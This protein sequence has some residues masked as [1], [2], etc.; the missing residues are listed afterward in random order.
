MSGLIYYFKKKMLIDYAEIYQNEQQS[1]MV[2]PRDFE[3]QVLKLFDAYEEK[4]HKGHW[5]EKAFCKLNG[6][7]WHHLVIECK[8]KAIRI[9]LGRL[10]R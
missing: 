1:N 9:F 3:Q 4:A 6:K 8:I 7:N 2:V 5:I 10:R